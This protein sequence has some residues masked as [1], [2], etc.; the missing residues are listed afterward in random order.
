[1]RCC[2]IIKLAHYFIVA[3]TRGLSPS[4]RFGLRSNS[5]SATTTTTVTT[6]DGSNV[7]LPSMLVS[8]S[9]TRKTIERWSPTACFLARERLADAAGV[10]DGDDD[11]GGAIVVFGG[12]GGGGK[13]HARLATLASLDCSPASSLTS[14]GG[15]GML[16]WHA[17]VARG[18]GPEARQHHVAATLLIDV[19]V[20]DATTTTTSTS[21]STTSPMS[22]ERVVLV[23]GGR[24]SPMAPFDD[25]HAL[26]LRG[27]ACACTVIDS[28]NDRL[29][30]LQLFCPIR[31]RERAFRVDQ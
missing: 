5:S 26:L 29:L 30:N 19:V 16:T 21:T 9:N 28:S 2:R 25:V 22:C 20:V 23:S 13:S 27:G 12:F 10:D 31:I 11:V 18:L 7:T 6:S 17:V 3:A 24:A 4:F 15:H 8:N 1:M 14:S